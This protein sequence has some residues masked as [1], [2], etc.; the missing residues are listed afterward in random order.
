MAHITRFILI[1]SFIGSIIQVKNTQPQTIKP[2]LEDEPNVEL[3]ARAAVFAALP[4]T[5]ASP[6]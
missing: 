4:G 6:R 2:H 1:S 3:I 5:A